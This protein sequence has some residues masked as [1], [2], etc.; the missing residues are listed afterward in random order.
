MQLQSEQ[1]DIGF[2]AYVLGVERFQLERVDIAFVQSVQ[3][4]CSV[5]ALIIKILSQNGQVLK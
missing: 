5:L 2:D 3:R 4:I 1:V